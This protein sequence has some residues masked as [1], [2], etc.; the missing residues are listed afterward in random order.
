MLKVSV[1]VTTP[2]TAEKVRPEVDFEKEKPTYSAVEAISDG[3]LPIGT[4]VFG[5]FA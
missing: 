2:L 4:V 5:A 3:F 1:V